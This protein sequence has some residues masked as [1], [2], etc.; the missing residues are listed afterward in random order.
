MM[1]SNLQESENVLKKNPNTCRLKSSPYSHD[2]QNCRYRHKGLCDIIIEYN[3]DNNI[4]YNSK[5]LE[6]Q[7]EILTNLKL[8]NSE[9]VLNLENLFYKIKVNNKIKNSGEI[10]P[11]KAKYENFKLLTDIQRV[12]QNAKHLTQKDKLL[13][14]QSQRYFMKLYLRQI[15]KG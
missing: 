15:N 7:I 9:P 13:Y 5:N 14:C 3:F 4:N 8:E 1:S 6:E 2:C 11:Q 12:L 10:F